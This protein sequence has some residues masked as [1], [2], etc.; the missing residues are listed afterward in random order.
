MTND[1]LHHSL[2]NFKVQ[3]LKVLNTNLNLGVIIADQ[4]TNPTGF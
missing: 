4:D 2:S 3:L 1:E